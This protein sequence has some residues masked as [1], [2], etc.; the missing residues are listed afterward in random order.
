MAA[1]ADWH[2]VSTESD[3]SQ[4][5]HVADRTIRSLGDELVISSFD[6]NDTPYLNRELSWL[7]FNAR[8][9]A[10]A[11]DTTV[12]LLERVRFLSIFSSNLDEFFQVRV[13]GVKDQVAGEV[14]VRSPDGRLPE[15]QLAAILD[16]VRSLSSEKQHIFSEYVRPEMVANGI[17]R[18]QVDELGETDRVY[19]SEL[20]ENRIFPVLTPLAIDPGHPFPYISDLSLNLAVT[21]RDPTTNRTRFARIKIPGTF[22]RYIGLPSAPESHF[23]LLEDV[24]SHHLDTLF[25]GMEI[26]NKQFFRVTRNA[27]LTYEEEEAEDLLS[28]VEMELRRRRFGRA[29]RL[30]TFGEVD[31]VILGLLLEELDLE[32]SDV[33]NESTPLDLT[34]LDVLAD[35]DRPELR[36]TRWTPVTP[37]AFR[38]K[39]DERIDMFARLAEG[40]VLVHHPYDSFTVSVAE[41]IHQASVDKSVLAIKMTLYRT[42]GDSPLIDSLVRAAEA[43]KQVAVLIELKARFDEQANIGWARRLEQAGV[44]VAY[45]LIGLKIHSKTI[46][47]VREE[48][49]TIRRYCHIGTGNYNHRTAR[50][51]EDLGLLT[52]D[53]EI[54]ADLAS[55]FNQLTGYGRDISYSR[56]L[57]AP[58]MLRERLVDMIRSE[59]AE[60]VNGRIIMKM[61][62]LVDIDLIDLLYEAAKEGVQIDLIVR[63]ICGLR[64]GHEAQLE[65]VGAAGRIRVRSIVGRFLEHSRI[66]YFGNG[67]GAGKPAYFLGS[68]DLMPRNLNRRIE[69]LT[70]VTDP[71][72]QSQLDVILDVLLDDD[73]LAWL[74]TED[75]SW[76]RNVGTD[77]SNAHELFQHLALAEGFDVR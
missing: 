54:G 53:Q 63:G 74:L 77:G 33:F 42:S 52:A 69:V 19:V 31:E 48:G 58:E 24:I 40:D 27:D 16:S 72:L 32:R 6:D 51:Y 71:Q 9:L 15:E 35:L 67:G 3:P 75:G 61:N 7:A 76:H 44:H 34:G 47:I 26:I 8:V 70:S 56:I 17:L 45:G 4:S 41:L 50:V 11:K 49:R 57:V 10:L 55:L 73:Q 21:L 5:E 59:T 18:H 23:V 14:A 66:Y 36:Y 29:I 37:V 68:A 65:P 13:A 20:F 1:S 43:G 39:N 12:P 30:E 2:S 46:M 62:S 38:P 25:S 64:P 60:G 28:A 22:P